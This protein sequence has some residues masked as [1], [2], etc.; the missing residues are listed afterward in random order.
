MLP[1]SSAKE[2]MFATLRRS[3][4]VNRESDWRASS[5][6]GR[7]SLSYAGPVAA[8]KECSKETETKHITAPC[9]L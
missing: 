4:G 6:Q 9:V 5:C 2:C 3:S 1:K 7:A 8:A